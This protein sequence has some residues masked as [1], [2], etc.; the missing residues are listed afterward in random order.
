M[1]AHSRLKQLALLF[2]AWCLA[3][4]G[5]QVSETAPTE[6]LPTSSGKMPSSAAMQPAQVQKAVTETGQRGPFGTS[7]SEELSRSLGDKQRAL[8]EHMRNREFEKALATLAVLER[9]FAKE[10]E[11]YPGGDKTRI[12]ALIGLNRIEDA[13]NLIQKTGRKLSNFPI[14]LALQ[15]R[16]STED[17]RMFLF[18]R[19]GFYMN[20]NFPQ[21][22]VGVE[23][24]AVAMVRLARAID[25]NGVGSLIVC[26]AEALE[27]LKRVKDQPL[28]AYLVADAYALEGNHREAKDYW[29]IASSLP[30]LMGRRAK[31]GAEAKLP[32]QR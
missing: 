12:E 15:G 4:C 13:A 22:V 23:D 9:E 27:V 25:A 7:K 17:A 8:G 10:G 11:V 5:P 18:E 31:Q 28:A 16:L 20:D 2:L 30:G 29:G 6:P 3:S 1:V 21:M 32:Q 14:V 24:D 26:K 19:S